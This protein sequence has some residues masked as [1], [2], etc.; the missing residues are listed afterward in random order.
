VRGNTVVE[1]SL[2]ITATGERQ[3]DP[4]AGAVRVA[5]LMLNKTQ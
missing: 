4:R 2:A 3:P 1:V 5:E